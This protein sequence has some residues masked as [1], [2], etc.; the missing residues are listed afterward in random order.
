MKASKQ[1][2]ELAIAS[3][4]SAERLLNNVAC[5]I[6]KAIPYNTHK[7]KTSLICFNL[8]LL[9][10][11]TNKSKHKTKNIPACT[12]LSKLTSSRKLTVGIYC[13]GKEH[14]NSIMKAQIILN[15]KE[16]LTTNNFK[17][18]ECSKDKKTRS[19]TPP[20]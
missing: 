12:N 5:I 19:K 14:S 3:S 6:S 11:K 10:S 18:E 16:Y 4:Q 7:E 1:P 2:A 20:K 13:P 9:L 8:F 15:I 17:T